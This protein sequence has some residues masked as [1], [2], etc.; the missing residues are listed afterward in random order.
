MRAFVEVARGGLV[1]MC[2]CVCVCACV[3]V[4]VCV[5]VCKHAC[6]LCMHVR[7]LLCLFEG[8]KGRRQA[9]SSKSFSGLSP[10]RLKLL[11]HACR[12]P[13]P[14]VRKERQ[15]DKG[16]HNT[17]KHSYTLTLS[18]SLSHTHTHTNTHTHTHTNTHTPKL[19]HIHRYTHRRQIHCQRSITHRSHLL[20][21]EEEQHTHTGGKI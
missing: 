8:T 5:Y 7:V 16:P 15:S 13:L 18:L 19:T 9:I 4:C 10:S 17:C 12:L 1:L 11:K 14:R 2:V 20:G 3:C 21:K 6:A